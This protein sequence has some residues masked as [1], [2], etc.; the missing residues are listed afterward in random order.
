MRTLA[1][2]LAISILTV[3]CTADAFL[4]RT[5]KTRECIGRYDTKGDLHLALT[6]YTSGGG[7]S[8]HGTNLT[9]DVSHPVRYV[10]IRGDRAIADQSI[11]ETK[12]YDVKSMLIASNSVHLLG[13]FYVGGIHHLFTSGGAWRRDHV[14]LDHT[15]DNYWWGNAVLSRDGS[16]CTFIL[17]DDRNSLRTTSWTPDDGWHQPQPLTSVDP[18]AWTPASFLREDGMSGVAWIQVEDKRVKR[19]YVMPS[20]HAPQAVLELTFPERLVRDFDIESV[21]VTPAGAKLISVTTWQH[22]TG[23]I[24]ADKRIVVHELVAD[25]TG[26]WHQ[27]NLGQSIEL[28]AASSPLLRGAPF[29]TQWADGTLDVLWTSSPSGAFCCAPSHTLHGSHFDGNTW[30]TP[31]EVHHSKANIGHVIDTFLDLDTN[32]VHVALFY[33][34]W[35]WLGHLLGSSGV[36]VL[37]LTRSE[38]D[39]K[40]EMHNQKVDPIN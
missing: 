39:R 38:L 14:E 21:H 32:T 17:N 1:T 34:P 25:E 18:R 9:N 4:L 22:R 7:V 20:S 16:L 8:I 2:V 5:G 23:R 26:T 6:R 12:N 27:R 3:G 36:G 30:S 40:K 37:S 10:R 13:D 11:P 35:G 31:Y 29:L 15:H 19:C 33:S 28:A 24:N